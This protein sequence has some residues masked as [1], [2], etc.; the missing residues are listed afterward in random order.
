MVLHRA[1]PAR[2]AALLS[3]DSPKVAAELDYWK[4]VADLWNT[5]V[6]AAR[7]S[8]TLSTLL[9]HSTLNTPIARY[10][11]CQLAKSGWELTSDLQHWLRSLFGIG[12]SKIQEDI[13][14]TIRA[15]MDRTAVQRVSLVH[16]GGGLDWAATTFHLQRPSLTRFPI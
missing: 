16:A 14:Q 1:F 11:L 5:A 3:T 6:T 13:F 9:T 15:E 8:P 12:Q 4:S 7:A 10:F 2:T